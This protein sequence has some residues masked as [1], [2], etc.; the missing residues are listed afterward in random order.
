MMKTSLIAGLLGV[1]LI[2]AFAVAEPSTV[3]VIDGD[4]IELNGERIRLWG[5]DAPEH[6]QP[7]GREATE[8]LRAFLNVKE[9]KCESQYY[10]RYHRSVSVCRAGPIDIG[11]YMVSTGHAIDYERYSHGYYRLEQETARK[12]GL[13][14]WAGPFVEPEAWRHQHKN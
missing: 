3:H 9:I 13:G 2:G 6:N 5:I 8:V 4:T 7:D 10:D 12:E 1:S 14:I 11:S